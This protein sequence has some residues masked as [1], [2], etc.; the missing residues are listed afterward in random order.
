[1]TPTP[2]EEKLM[3]YSW[4]GEPIA[5]IKAWAKD[6]GEQMVRYRAERRVPNLFSGRMAT[7]VEESIMPESFYDNMRWSDGWFATEIER[8]NP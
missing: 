4:R 5:D 8:F 1:M 7:E 3:A 6:R 2:P